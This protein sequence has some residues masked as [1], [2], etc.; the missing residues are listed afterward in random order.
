L[1]GQYASFVLIVI[2]PLLYELRSSGDAE[3]GALPVHCDS[4]LPQ[5]AM[6]GA[7]LAWGGTRSSQQV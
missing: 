5:D 1:I 6:S 7:S 2:T 4:S 3:M